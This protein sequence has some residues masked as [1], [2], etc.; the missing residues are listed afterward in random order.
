MRGPRRLC[1]FLTPHFTA[2]VLIRVLGLYEGILCE[3]EGLLLS[4][5]SCSAACSMR[6]ANGA[7]CSIDVAMHPL[8]MH[9][10]WSRC[11]PLH[12]H[13]AC[14]D[15][16]QQPQ[17]RIIETVFLV[18]LHSSHPHPLY[19]LILATTMMAHS[20]TILG[21]HADEHFLRNRWMR[22]QRKRY[23]EYPSIS[24]GVGLRPVIRRYFQFQW[25]ANT[26]TNR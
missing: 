4:A 2:G 1:T 12:Q 26:G 16:L 20:E 15:T 7:P 22:R 8:I 24:C 10:D 3:A 11:E 13:A 5:C 25:L 9:E 6:K 17:S 18:D 14:A 19:C 21:P 23:I